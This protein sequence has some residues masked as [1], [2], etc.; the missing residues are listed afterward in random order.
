MIAEKNLN[1]KSIFDKSKKYFG[2]SMNFKFEKNKV[3]C[4]FLFCILAFVGGAINGF[5]GT[6]GGIIF[7][8]L[9]SSITKNATKDNYATSLCATIVLS[10]I[11][12][13]SYFKN[14]NIDFELI[15]RC[16]AFCAIGGIIGAYLTDK[17]KAS[18]LNIGFASLIIY[19]GFSM[20]FR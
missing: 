13:F 1:C 14:K 15:L 10:I 8:L 18:W 4:T 20:I 11:G 16:G 6:G 2:E 17:I 3:L 5:L 9:L 19:S 7:V 12:A